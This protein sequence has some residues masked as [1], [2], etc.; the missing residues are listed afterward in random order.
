[1]FSG[2]FFAGRSAD[3]DAA[4]LTAFAFVLHVNVIWI[5]VQFLYRYIFL[6]CPEKSYFLLCLQIFLRK[7]LVANVEIILIQVDLSISE[8]E[9]ELEDNGHQFRCMLK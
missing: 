4:I 5:P 3:F 7:L 6:C 2:G 9:N 8:N 1:M